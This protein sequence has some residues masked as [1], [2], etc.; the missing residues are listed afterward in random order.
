MKID[1]TPDS[2]LRFYCG[3]GL[4]IIIFGVAYFRT[5]DKQDK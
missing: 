5:K 1:L 3:L 4:L 2:N